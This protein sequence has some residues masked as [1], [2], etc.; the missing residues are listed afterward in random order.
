MSATK[1]RT[2]TQDA[3]RSPSHTSSHPAITATQ[4]RGCFLGL[5]IGDTF[6][7]PYEGGT[8][9]RLLWRLLGR[10]RYG[11]LRYTDD[12][13][14]A[15]DIAHSIL[16]AKQ[17]DQ[18][19]LAHTLANSYRW[20]RGYGPSAAKLLKSIRAGKNW[21]SVNCAQF[22]EGSF[23]NGAA[24]RA[25]IVALCFPYDIEQIKTTV[26]Q[27]AEITHAHTLGIEGATL[28]A[29][30]TALSLTHTPPLALL[31][32]LITETQ[33]AEFKKKLTVCRS[34][35]AIDFPVPVTMLKQRLGNGMTA[36][37]SCITAIYFALQYRAQS[38]DAMLTHII[39]LGGDTDTIAAMAGAIW[40]ASHGD[41]PL[42]DKRDQIEDASYI[43]QL[44]DA[45]YAFAHHD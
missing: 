21:R 22:K 43:L 31:D 12:T 14:M 8:M 36:T 38:F 23:G 42:S 13:Q 41:S 7:A 29:I 2:P 18:S 37:D 30:A 20:S 44:A 10:N 6:C 4:Y 28:I 25:P 40:G 33:H 15:M 45:L 5:A 19:H 24:M 17:L 3:D 34:L 27:S 35:I 1:V 26:A 16:T 32:R 11:L 9:E 39:Q